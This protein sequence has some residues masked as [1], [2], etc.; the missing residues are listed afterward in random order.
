MSNLATGE[1]YVVWMSRYGKGPKRVATFGSMVD[2]QRFLHGKPWRIE[3]Y[4]TEELA[5]RASKSLVRG[6][7]RRS[8]SGGGFY[9]T[10]FC[11]F[12]HSLKTGRPIG[13]EC[14][15]LPPK[16]LQAE[17]DG[18]I[19]DAIELF[20]KKGPIVRGRSSPGGKR[21]SS[22][23]RG[24]Q[25]PKIPRSWPV[26]PLRPGQ[27]ARDPV[28]CGTCGLSWDDAKVTSMTPTPSGRCP[29][30]GFHRYD[31]GK[32]RSAPQRARK[33]GTGRVAHRGA[34]RAARGNP[35]RAAAYGA[36]K[37]RGAFP[38]GY[39]ITRPRDY[40]SKNTVLWDVTAPNG[41]WVGE[42][43]LRRSAVLMARRHNQRAG[44][45]KVRRG[46]KRQVASKLGALVN[47]INRLTK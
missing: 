37:A 44:F 13:H 36:V 16:G 41:E 10:S 28:T 4:I 20:Q 7:K 1:V 35:A 46:T 3:A 24:P 42:F 43:P 9:V 26:Q 8:A 39:I 23:G 17:R 21:R 45:G 27:V 2:A 38:K 11:N 34:K 15:I 25:G 18:R 31:G 47:D 29:F 14:Y 30:E 22:K 5:T 32:R 33:A 40:A 6:G 12:A 19:D